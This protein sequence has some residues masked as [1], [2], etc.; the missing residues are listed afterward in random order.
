MGIVSNCSYLVKFISTLL[1]IWICFRT[2]PWCYPACVSE[3][4]HCLVTEECS[5]IDRLWCLWSWTISLLWWKVKWWVVWVIWILNREA[6]VDWRWRWGSRWDR[7]VNP[8]RWGGVGGR[9]SR[10]DSWWGWILGSPLISM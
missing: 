7:W 9:C 2:V 5:F 4:S 10:D 6:C 3:K 1:A 8:P